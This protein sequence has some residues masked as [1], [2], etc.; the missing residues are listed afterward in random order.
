MLGTHRCTLSFNIF[1]LTSNNN[2]PNRDIS[3]FNFT[4]A[5]VKA[6]QICLSTALQGL[7][8]LYSSFLYTNSNQEEITNEGEV[9]LKKAKC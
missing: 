2:S 9:K 8:S 1:P 7:I 6:S 3:S 4:E 5:S